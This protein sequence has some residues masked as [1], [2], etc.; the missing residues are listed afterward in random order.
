MTPVFWTRD[1]SFNWLPQHAATPS[2]PRFIFYVYGG[3][4]NRATAWLASLLPHADAEPAS[5][6]TTFHVAMSFESPE[7]KISGAFLSAVA[8]AAGAF[9]L[10]ISC[11]SDVM[12]ALPLHQAMFMSCGWAEGAGEVDEWAFSAQHKTQLVSLQVRLLTPCAPQS[13]RSCASHP[14]FRFSCAGIYFKF[15]AR[16]RDEAA[17]FGCL[18][19]QSAEVRQRFLHVRQPYAPLCFCS[20][21]LPR[22]VFVTFFACTTAQ[23]TTSRHLPLHSSTL[24]LPLRS[25]PLPSPPLTNQQAFYFSVV[26]E[27][28]RADFYFSAKLINCFVHGVVPVYWGA[29]SIAMFFNISGIIV[30]DSL[31]QVGAVRSSAPLALQ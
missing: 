18:E 30:F 20:V 21:V 29:P 17:S 26:I 3:V 31:Q 5:N 24:S 22:C 16:S 23:L 1:L 14:F 10:F 12:Q 27:N 7:P 28:M 19:G 9:D 8:Q 2:E 11:T 6:R 4:T 13:A 15:H 25:Q